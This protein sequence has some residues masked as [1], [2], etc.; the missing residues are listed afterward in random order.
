MDLSSP[1]HISTSP[2]TTEPLAVI[3][4]VISSKNTRFRFWRS[5]K[6]PG[7]SVG[8]SVNVAGSLSVDNPCAASLFTGLVHS[9]ICAAGEIIFHP[10]RRRITRR[11]CGTLRDDAAHRPT[12]LRSASR[13]VVPQLDGHGY[14]PG[15]RPCTF[16][17]RANN[18]EALRRRFVKLNVIEAAK[19]A[20]LYFVSPYA[21]HKV[22]LPKTA[23]VPPNHA[24]HR[25]RASAAR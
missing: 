24:V 22:S 9:C 16:A 7:Y 1:F 15:S 25:S 18:S 23:Q 3:H 8:H 20:C 5:R 11:S 21:F 19:W 12:P 2:T 14:S 17:F 4:P 6:F 10:P 13:P